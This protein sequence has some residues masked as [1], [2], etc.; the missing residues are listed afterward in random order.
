MSFQKSVTL[1]SRNGKGMGPQVPCIELGIV[2]I[3]LLWL[4]MKIINKQ[5]IIRIEKSFIW[6]K[7]KTIAPK[8]GRQSDDCEQL[9]Q[10]SLVFRPVLHLVRTKNTKQLRDPFLQGFQKQTNKT[11]Q[12]V[13]REPVCPQHLESESYHR[14]STSIGIPGRK[15]FNL[16]F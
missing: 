10:R 13:H 2:D 16:Y 11:D 3:S 6:A 12:H 9:L 5:S 14:R 8:T 1:H 4:S 7:L 15:A